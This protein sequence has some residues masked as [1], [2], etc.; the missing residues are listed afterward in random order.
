MERSD[1]ARRSENLYDR[2]GQL[3]SKNLKQEERI[4]EL[5]ETAFIKILCDVRSCKHCKDGVCKHTTIHLQG[6]SPDADNVIA[7]SEFCEP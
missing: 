4:K 7:C 6:C 2:I 1:E 5:E 3:R